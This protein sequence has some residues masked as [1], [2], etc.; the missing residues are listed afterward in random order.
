M[1][2]EKTLEFIEETLDASDDLRVPVQLSAL[3]GAI[4]LLIDYV[5]EMENRSSEGLITSNGSES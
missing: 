2:R 1:N 3:F 4:R 5:R